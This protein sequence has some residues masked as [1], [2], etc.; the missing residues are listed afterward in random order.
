[1]RTAAAGTTGLRH[2]TTHLGD[3]AHVAVLRS[4]L[5]AGAP[6]RD[7]ALGLWT[8]DPWGIELR[9]EPR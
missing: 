4:R 5:A 8:A 9:V 2:W 7:D 6:L 1:M 3:A